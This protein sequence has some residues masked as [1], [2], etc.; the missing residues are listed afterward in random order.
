MVDQERDR[1]AC[2]LTRCAAATMVQRY[3]N[4]DPT[5]P[6]TSAGTKRP[7]ALRVSAEPMMAMYATSSMSYPMAL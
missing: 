3:A 2:V 5:I 1:D 7:D 4:I 6:S